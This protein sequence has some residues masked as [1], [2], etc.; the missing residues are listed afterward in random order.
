MAAHASDPFQLPPALQAR[1]DAAGV[2][3][4]ASFQA[5]LAAD[6][7]LRAEFEAFLQA[8][9]HLLA[10][11]QV[12]ALLQAFAQVQDGAQMLEFWRGVPTD[13]RTAHPGGGT[14]HRPGASRR[15][16]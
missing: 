10:A 7:Q 14:G 13:M 8:N 9:P 4:N 5:A 15:G 16:R 2:H 11:M 12:N 1:L 3:D 6:P